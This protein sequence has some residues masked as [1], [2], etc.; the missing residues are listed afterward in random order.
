MLL[1]LEEIFCAPRPRGRIYF[2]TEK[3]TAVL[4]IYPPSQLRK[5]EIDI[6]YKL[7]LEKWCDSLTMAI[8]SLNKVA[9]VLVP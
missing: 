7:T 2:A 4:C 6:P 9:W 5:L 3:G 1:A 8:S